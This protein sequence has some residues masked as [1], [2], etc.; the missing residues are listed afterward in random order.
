[1]RSDDS[2]AVDSNAPQGLEPD[3][4]RA[5]HHDR[6]VDGLAGHDI[7]LRPARVGDEANSQQDE[8]K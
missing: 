4:L 7:G 3:N 8:A 1:V 2:F 6:R 5:E